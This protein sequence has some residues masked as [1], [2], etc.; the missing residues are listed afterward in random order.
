MG[1]KSTTKRSG[2]KRPEHILRLL[3]RDD[4]P[5]SP[6]PAS[7]RWYKVIRARRYYFGKLD[8]PDGALDNYLD[9]KDDLHAGRKP[10]GRRTGG[11]AVRELCNRFLK[12]KRDLVASGDMKERTWTD[13]RDACAVVVETFGPNR[14]VD[15]LR[16]E[17]FDTL[18]AVLARRHS[19]I[20]LR[21]VIQ[22]VRSVFKWASDMDHVERP[23][24]FG[25][26]FK[27]PPKK[28]IRR[29]RREAGEKLFTAVEIRAMINNA[30]VPMK[31]I[32]LLGVNGGLGNTDIAELPIKA[33]DL[34]RGWIDYPRPKTE[35]ER[36]IPLWPETVKAIRA[37]MEK[38]P[39]PKDKAD[40]GLLFI[41][42][43]GRRWVRSR[44]IDTDPDNPK[45]SLSDAV[46]LQFSKLRKKCGIEADGRG[47]Y[48][49]R[50]TFRTIADELPDS[51]AIDRVMGHETPGI[52]THY[53]E[54]IDD[55][56][57]RAV[58]NHVPTARSGLYRR[59]LPRLRE[60]RYALYERRAGRA[61]QH[62]PAAERPYRHR[63]LIRS[64]AGGDG[65]SASGG[66][67]RAGVIGDG[68][69][70]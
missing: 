38:R 14:A 39:Q 24:K 29:E 67:G 58:A 69:S 12:A 61:I 59:L 47:Y 66:H 13:Y 52:A 28:R 44:L 42:K 23:L 57:L 25:P 19:A 4:F 36:R 49:L 63:Q 45:L 51:V 48:S 2:R 53:R 15:D 41:T 6:H 10:R 26:H 3:P 34:D 7:G 31:A 65:P 35:V 60:Q 68:D 5:L 16:P 30:D 43:Y 22:R 20:V 54:R 37:Y 33:F 46:G 50:H 27:S 32:V 55:K 40:E 64:P 56:R 11:I 17:D 21:N 9:Q 18:R 8:D 1:T 70:I 62:R